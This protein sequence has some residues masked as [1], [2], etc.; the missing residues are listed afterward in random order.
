[1][2]RRELWREILD[3]RDDSL[4]LIL[5]QV[6]LGSHVTLLR[7]DGLGHLHLD[8]LRGLDVDD[9]VWWQPQPCEIMDS[10]GCR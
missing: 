4:H 7:I 3:V 9:R 2:T 8:S 5:A 10:S 6:I 1:M